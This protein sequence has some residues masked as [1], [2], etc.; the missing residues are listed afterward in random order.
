MEEKTLERE[1]ADDAVSLARR[2]EEPDRLDRRPII[3]SEEEF[4]AIEKML[5]EPLSPEEIEGRRR[6]EAGRMWEL[7][8]SAEAL[9]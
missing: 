3:V 8:A 6:L 2:V 1:D 9:F 5:E 4:R 7:P